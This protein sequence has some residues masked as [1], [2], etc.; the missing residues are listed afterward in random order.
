MPWID[1]S[2]LVLNKK[3]TYLD[4]FLKNTLF[5]MK[6]GN[7]TKK[8][9]FLRKYR[10]ASTFC[11]EQVWINRF[12][13]FKYIG[14][15]MKKLKFWRKKN[16]DFFN[17]IKKI[18]PFFRRKDINLQLKYFR[19]FLFDPFRNFCSRIW[20]DLRKRSKLILSFKKSEKMPCFIKCWARHREFKK[21][22]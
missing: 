18:I 13:A 12:R 15:H 14:Y 5:W 19:G 21:L 8:V 22:F 20:Q 10:V 4:I 1:L 3:L 16:S 17:K 7:L 9:G 6:F 2:T 11:L